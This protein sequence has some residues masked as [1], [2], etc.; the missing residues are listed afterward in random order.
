[1]AM[2]PAERRRRAVRA[3]QNARRRRGLQR[4][5]H[6][7]RVVGSHAELQ[8]KIRITLAGQP[9]EFDA[10]HL[11]ALL[12][13]VDAHLERWERVARGE[14]ADA[15]GAAWDLGG[16]IVDAPFAAVGT[17]L[18]GVLLPPHLLDEL[19]ADGVALMDGV[20][21]VA[22]K[23]IHQALER[24]LLGGATPHQVMED[25]TATLKGP[26]PFRYVTFRAE[27]VVRTEMGRVQSKAGHRRLEDAAA[28]VDGLQ[29]EWVWSGKTRIKH[30]A[31]NGQRRAVSKPF[32][33][34]GEELMYPRDPAGSAANTVM[35]GCESVPWMD[36]W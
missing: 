12:R 24:G 21:V 23:R 1:M 3:I 16:E 25:I 13:E 27:V 5:E 35:C 28:V 26:G 9:S 8:Q 20:G 14:V 19:V 6:V 18:P 29:K 11:P 22:R 31:V 2:S 33:V 7:E 15:L 36:S 10:A 4:D 32:S 17:A 34:G 30:Q